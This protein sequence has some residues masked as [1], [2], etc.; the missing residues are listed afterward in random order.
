MKDKFSEK[1]VIGLYKAGRKVVDIAV[2]M[3]YK[4]G[5]GQNRV[6]HC[7]IK[8]GI[9]AVSCAKTAAREKK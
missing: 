1:R 3:G 6:R 2:A 9:Y 8:A 4:R 7:L 5:H